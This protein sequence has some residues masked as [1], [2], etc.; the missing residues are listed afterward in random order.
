MTKLRERVWVIEMW[1]DT[2]RRAAPRWEPTVGVALTLR[3]A[4]QT[5][6]EWHKRNPVDRFR[7]RLYRRAT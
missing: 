7:V 2:Y 6:R 4:R 1:A 3:D 5:C